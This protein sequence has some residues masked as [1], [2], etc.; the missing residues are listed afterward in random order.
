MT[1][2]GRC[3]CGAV[4]FRVRGELPYVVHCHCENC[5]RAHG[6][7]FFSAAFIA[8]K[9]FEVSSGEEHLKTAPFHGDQPGGRV[10]CGQC[11][12]HV[13]NKLDMFPGLMNFSLGALEEA[14]TDLAEAI[15]INT[16]SKVAWL[17]LPEGATQYEEFPPDIAEQLARVLAD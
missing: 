16:E 5:R 17:T 3:H 1:R 15:H 9:N 14:P 8:A 12:S 4:A 10:F 6:A 11:G 2:T 7:A 13:F